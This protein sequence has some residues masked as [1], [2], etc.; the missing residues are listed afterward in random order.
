MSPPNPSRTGVIFFVLYKARALQM[1]AEGTAIVD[2]GGELIR[3]GALPVAMDDEIG[4]AVWV[5]EALQSPLKVPISID[6]RKPELV[7]AAIQAGAGYINDINVLRET[8]AL[9]LAAESALPVCL[10][11]LRGEQRSIQADPRNKNVVDEV[12][13]TWQTLQMN[14][15][16]QNIN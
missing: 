3:P 11:H 15:A 9:E 13:A 7:R 6:T 10:M 4:R 5:I 1:E 8:G 2:I 14:V 12:A 16:L